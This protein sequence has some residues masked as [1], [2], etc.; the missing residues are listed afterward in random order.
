MDFTIDDPI[1]GERTLDMNDKNFE[2]N[3][4][5]DQLK[6]LREFKRRKTSP[7]PQKLDEDI[8][9]YK[10]ILKQPDPNNAAIKYSQAMHDCVW[11]KTKKQIVDELGF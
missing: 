6:L 7:N 9:A 8:D 11:A 10:R 4:I 3:F 2:S 1:L 5:R